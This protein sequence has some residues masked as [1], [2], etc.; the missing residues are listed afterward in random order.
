M[1]DRSITT[2]EEYYSGSWTDIQDLL[3]VLSIGEGRMAQITE[4]TT[5]RF[6]EMVDRDI[7]AI[8]TDTYQ[9]P[10]RSFNQVRMGG[11]ILG[12]GSVSG[13]NPASPLR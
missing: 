7:D 4:V 5:N 12:P 10:I 3:R 11:P 2:G 6:Q 9:T 13:R 1:A 8:L